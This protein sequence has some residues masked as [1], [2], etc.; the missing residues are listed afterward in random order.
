[1]SLET[2]A[3]A[4]EDVLVDS[5]SY[6]L[7]PGGNYVTRRESA[8][9][10]PSGGNV[11]NANNG[12]R[13]I[14]I[15]LISENG[16]LDTSTVQINYRLTSLDSVADTSSARTRI[17]LLGHQASPFGRVRVIMGGQQVEDIQSF[18][19]YYSLMLQLA[20]E[21]FLKN[22]V[23]TGPGLQDPF[24][25]QRHEYFALK[26]FG[27]GHSKTMSFPLLCGTLNQPKWL[28]LKWISCYLELELCPPEDCC[29]TLTTGTSP[30]T[31]FTS[32]FQIDNVQ[33]KGDLCYLDD[34]L[35]E[36]F[37]KVLLSGRK[38]PINIVTFSHTTHALVPG[39]DAPTIIST[40]ACS[41]LK[42]AFATFFA[43]RDNLNS[44][45]NTFDSPLGRATTATGHPQNSANT[46]VIPDSKC[47]IYQWVKDSTTY[48][49][50][51]VRS[52]AESWNQLLK[53]L[54]Q[55]NSTQHSIGISET[56]YMTKS[57]VI[58]NDF[59]SLLQ[60]GFSG[61]NMRTGGQLAL[62]LNN[63][64]LGGTVSSTDAAALKKCFVLL[65]MDTVVEIG[66]DGVTVLD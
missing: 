8:T 66:F 4:I 55:H 54:G 52:F 45:V 9:W 27:P 22:F 2:T 18:N 13:V 5:L 56:E 53:S 21:S 50:F 6:K 26:W 15:P 43:T 32:N 58:A 42:T 29:R 20:P 35:S 65:M 38:L 62:Q 49:V 63:L 1:M 33:V 3:S 44:E 61:A 46:E 31:T 34:S 28:P 24:P 14:R 36:E 16:W 12:V 57:Y 60:V 19:R 37:S 59:E 30:T 48:P 11:Y 51:P 64:T 25:S 23:A 10:F 41:R 40:R 17:Q 47:P 39:E 7:K